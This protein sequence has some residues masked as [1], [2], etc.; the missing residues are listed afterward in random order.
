MGVCYF[1]TKTLGAKS[2][3]TTLIYKQ[4][5]SR[6]RVTFVRAICSVQCF[7]MLNAVVAKQL[8]DSYKALGS[9]VIVKFL[10]VT[11][12]GFC[13]YKRSKNR[14]PEGQ[15]FG[16]VNQRRKC[17]PEEEERKPRE[18]NPQLRRQQHSHDFAEPKTEHAVFEK[19]I[20]VDKADQHR[21]SPVVSQPH[22]RRCA[23]VKPT[24]LACQHM[25]IGCWLLGMFWL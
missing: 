22:Q 11:V 15:I 18:V 4:L 24:F 17:H 2:V 5:Q 21:A 10:Q 13:C 1:S 12:H 25:I 6:Q 16:W 9:H 20:R 3:L 7:H 19:H 8:V 14:N 23:A